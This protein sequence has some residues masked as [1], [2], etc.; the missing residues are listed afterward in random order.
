MEFLKEIKKEQK[1]ISKQRVVKSVMMIL[2]WI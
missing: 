1:M 2:E